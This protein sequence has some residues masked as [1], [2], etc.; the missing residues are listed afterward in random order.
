MAPPATLLEVGAAQEPQ[1]SQSTLSGRA[2]S[3]I[4]SLTLLCSLLVAALAVVL[5]LSLSP[6]PSSSLPPSSTS[7]PFLTSGNPHPIG[8][9]PILP[10]ESVLAR[11]GRDMDL[12]RDLSVDPCDD[13]YRYSCGGWIDAQRLRAN[14]S[15][16]TKGFEL[17]GIDNAVIIREVIEADW[18]IVTPFFQACANVD[19]I[20]RLG[21]EPVR[22]F[23]DGLDPSKVMW[24]K[25][26][27]FG[28]LGRLRREIRLTS[29]FSLTV[30]ANTSN[31]RQPVLNM[32]VGGTTFPQLSYYYGPS[33]VTARITDAIRQLLE[34]VGDEPRNARAWA[35]RVVAFETGLIKVFNGIPATQEWQEPTEQPKLYTAEEWG[36]KTLQDEKR[37]LA[38]ID[39]SLGVDDLEQLMPD[40]PIRTFLNETGLLYVL[41]RAGMPLSAQLT[42]SVAATYRALDN[43]LT[44]VDP[45]TLM[46]Y[47]RWH[48]LNISTPYLPAAF[49]E[50]HRAHFGAIED[51][52]QT[53][54][55]Y[56]TCSQS[57]VTQ[58]PDLFGRF[59][60]ARRLSPEQRDQARQMITWIRNAF[61]RNL[62]S[63]AWMD[64]ATRKVAAEKAYAMLELVGGPENGNWSDYSEVLI[65]RDRYYDNWQQIQNLRSIEE[66]ERLTQPLSRG[67]FTMNPSIVN[68][69]YNAVQNAMQFPAGIL[70]DPFYNGDFPM[71]VNLGAIG[72][73]MGHEMIHGFD[74]N[75]RQFDKDGLRRQ[76]WGDNVIT[77]FGRKTKCLIDQ[78][79]NIYVQGSRI[80][81]TFTLG[82]NIAD[83]GGLHMAFLAL[84]WYKEQLSYFN[85]ED[86]IPPSKN[87]LTSDQLFYWAHAQTWCTKATPES[88]ATQVRTD[89]HSP[90]EARVWAPVV[91]QEGFARAYNCP[92]GSRMNPPADRKCDLY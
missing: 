83:N 14:Q 59:F 35:E 69:Q 11:I 68:A 22:W 16:I 21:Y 79:D 85:L 57:V 38:V 36:Q 87:P 81:G 28:W 17:A 10:K 19:A 82:E 13:F 48:A 7:L 9:P 23:L 58:L 39:A 4:L 37:A 78:Y 3:I 12:S 40:T 49:Q 26:E 60:M 50:T 67:R 41:D 51:V 61:E 56:P 18:P 76:W 24:Q 8:Q 86:P 43:F 90:G 71:S 84:Q 15:R 5:F 32:G 80:N 34:M 25:Q 62:P 6:S 53:P 29:I 70:V 73:V 65:R 63:V 54:D 74:N 31:P 20:Q 30:A 66:W 46:L 55:R 52:S 47:A 92:V 72:L 64:D 88:I 1:P 27:V 91:N 45:V 75:G 44:S 42:D 77:A 33:N 89:V 2:R